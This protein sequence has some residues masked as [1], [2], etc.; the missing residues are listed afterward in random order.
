MLGQ[1]LLLTYR[2]HAHNLQ[3][4]LIQHRQML[5]LRVAQRAVVVLRHVL[6]RQLR[7][8]SPHLTHVRLARLR[9]VQPQLQHHHHLLEGGKV[10][11]QRAGS[12]EEETNSRLLAHGVQHV[13]EGVAFDVPTCL[14]VGLQEIEVQ[15][16]D[17]EFLPEEG[18]AVGVA[19]VCE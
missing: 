12:E 3:Q 7:I 8:T 13:G 16:A 5:P 10:V 14:L 9:S 19:D 4:D 6:E 18:A 17:A 11:Q 2:H 15:R 1:H